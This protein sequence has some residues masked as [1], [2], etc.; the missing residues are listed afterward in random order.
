MST[1]EI[2]NKVISSMDTSAAYI[3]ICKP[4]SSSEPAKFFQSVGVSETGSEMYAHL[5]KDAVDP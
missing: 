1:E 4:I 2:A 5:Q 3:R